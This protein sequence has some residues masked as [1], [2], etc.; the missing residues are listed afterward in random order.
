MNLDH[1]VECREGPVSGRGLPATFPMRADVDPENASLLV[2][3]VVG[4]GRSDDEQDRRLAKVGLELLAKAAQRLP[5]DAEVSRHRL[6]DDGIRARA[7]L[8]GAP[9]GSLVDGDH[10]PCTARWTMASTSARSTFAAS[11][12]RISRSSWVCTVAA[13][14]SRPTSTLS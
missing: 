3:H 1:R 13:V 11:S 5:I 6:E 12:A 8:G 7:V 9:S 2:H 4:Y 10:R 14:F